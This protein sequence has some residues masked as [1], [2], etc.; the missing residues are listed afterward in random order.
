MTAPNLD[1]KDKKDLRRFCGHFVQYMDMVTENSPGPL[2]DSPLPN[3]EADKVYEIFIDGGQHEEI[4]KF[5]VGFRR[6]KA[7]EEGL[8]QDRKDK[9]LSEELY[10]KSED[11]KRKIDKVAMDYVKLFDF[12]TDVV[13]A[14]LK[15]PKRE[16]RDKI[17][18]ALGHVHKKK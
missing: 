6:C 8:E 17:A 9:M 3:A 5:L 1:D 10:A 12:A 11:G 18:K 14:I 2:R 7:R 13:L 15:V 4:M 16:A